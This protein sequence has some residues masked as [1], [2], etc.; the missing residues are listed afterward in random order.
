MSGMAQVIDVNSP[1]T[2]RLAQVEMEMKIGR[3]YF[4]EI[5]QNGELVGGAIC[6]CPK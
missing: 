5:V 2:E 1:D 4:S 3:K 6:D